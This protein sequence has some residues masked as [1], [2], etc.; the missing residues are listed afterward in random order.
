MKVKEYAGDPLI[1]AADALAS[2]AA[3]LDPLRSQDVDPE[4]VYFRHKGIL[5]PWNSRLRRELT[6][7]MASQWA[8]MCSRLVIRGGEATAR[9]VPLTATWLLLPNQGRRTL[10]EAMARMKTN[11]AKRHVLQTLAGMY[12]GNTLLF[13]WGLMP[14][15][16]CTLCWHAAETQTHVQCLCPDLKGERIR[17]H[18]WLAELLW[19]SIER[20]AQGWSL[21]REVTVVG[22]SVITVPIDAVGEWQR[23]CGELAYEDLVLVREEA[24]LSSSIRRKRPDAWAVHWEPRVVYILEFTCPNDGDLN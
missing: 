15:P 20:A 7:V 21:H 13:K 11:T 4:G 8:A 22:L 6:Q 23:M 10:G 3:E 12:P 14:S 17:V 2:A 24:A 16:Q 1:E 9:N 18:H 5:V 19:G